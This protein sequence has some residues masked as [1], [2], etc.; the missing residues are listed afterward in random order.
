MKK[1]EKTPECT[2]HLDGAPK[3][4]GK[5]LFSLCLCAF[6]VKDLPFLGLYGILGKSGS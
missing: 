4:Y 3:F 1:K 6:V 2:N 5:L